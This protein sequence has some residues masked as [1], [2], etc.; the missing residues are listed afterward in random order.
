MIVL[1]L[2]HSNF[3][4]V[5]NVLRIYITNKYY[6]ARNYFKMQNKSNRLNRVTDLKLSKTLR[7]AAIS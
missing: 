1:F 2:N 6:S 4:R 7:I 5:K 3:A